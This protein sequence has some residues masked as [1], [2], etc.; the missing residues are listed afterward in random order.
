MRS[1]AAAVVFVLALP[2]QAH[3]AGER[4]T[5]RCYSNWGT[6]E[7]MVLAPRPTLQLLLDL[8]ASP[9]TDA[10]LYHRLWRPSSARLLDY[11]AFDDEVMLTFERVQDTDEISRSIRSDPRLAALGLT[12]AAANR[13]DVCGVPPP[14][15]RVTVT[16]Y[17]NRL[18]NHY[19]LSSS[20]LENSAI[21][22]G[23]AGPGWER[24]G[25]SFD[26]SA[27]APCG[28]PPPVFRFYTRGAN[29]H[30][31][32]ADPG[33]CGFLRNNDPGWLFEGEA[34]GAR[35]PVD[36]ACTAGTSPVYRLYNN[37]WM[38]NDSNHRFVKRLD[39]Y[40]QMQAQ[41]WAGEGV[42]MCLVNPPS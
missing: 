42:A 18:T 41:G 23:A 33:E 29:S 17:F 32:T 31:F 8:V 9:A 36:G 35:V 34:F 26:A 20:A 24:T 37:R 12:N 21:D 16:E 5:A 10:D 11:T 38:H 1:L 30:F 15:T 14:P 13:R 40:Q 27:S 6:G 22:S 39:L 3:A 25:E 2:A 28:G 7:V 19:F 4:L